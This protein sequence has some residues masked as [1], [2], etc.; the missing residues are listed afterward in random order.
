MDD[1][2]LT[3]RDLLLLRTRAKAGEKLTALARIDWLMVKLDDS[4]A[5]KIPR[6][7]CPP[8][9]TGDPWPWCCGGVPV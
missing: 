3:M 6:P 8:S 2:E 4:D 7:D 9:C 5:D 1:D